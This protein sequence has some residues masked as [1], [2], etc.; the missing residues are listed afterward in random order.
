MLHKIIQNITWRNK[1]YKR[2]NT[3]G[4]QYNR[5]Q[6]VL[7]AVHVSVSKLANYI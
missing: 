5:K 4:T 6:K 3:K 7:L 1:L 2:Y